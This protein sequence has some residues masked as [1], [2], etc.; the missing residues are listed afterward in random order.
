[1]SVP[2]TLIQLHDAHGGESIFTVATG[3]PETPRCVWEYDYSRDFGAAELP[4][5][6]S[7]ALLEYWNIKGHHVYGFAFFGVSD[8]VSG[9]DLASNIVGL[10]FF[11]VDGHFSCVESV[12]RK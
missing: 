9:P 11:L 3:A 6:R 8:P 1:M 7:A 4:R 10:L 12:T 5:I 2:R